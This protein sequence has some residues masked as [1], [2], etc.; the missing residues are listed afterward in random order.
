MANMSYC[1]FENTHN[2]LR[3]CLEVLKDPDQ[4]AELSVLEARHAR[5]MLCDIVEAFVELGILH[6]DTGTIVTGGIS[7]LFEAP[8]DDEEDE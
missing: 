5:I 7:D 8:D 6:A 4:V 1:R 3:T 2:D